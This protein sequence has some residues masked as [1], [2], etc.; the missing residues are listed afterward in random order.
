[1]HFQPCFMNELCQPEEC[2]WYKGSSDYNREGQIFLHD[3]LVA[4]LRFWG[5]GEKITFG[6]CNFGKDTQRGLVIL[7]HSKENV[8]FHFLFLFHYLAKLK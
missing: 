3:I 2:Q 1:M 4:Q 7:D 6:F 8:S 5:E